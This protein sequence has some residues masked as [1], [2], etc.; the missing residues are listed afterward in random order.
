ML[1]TWGM[2][3]LFFAGNDAKILFSKVR[4]FYDYKNS[5]FIAEHI[6]KVEKYR[7]S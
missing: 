5:I 7:E 2:S 1:V 6:E 4:F 3:F